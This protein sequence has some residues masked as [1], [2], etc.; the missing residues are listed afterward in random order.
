MKNFN[1]KALFAAVFFAFGF[2]TISS[3]LSA[4][5]RSITVYQFRRVPDEKREEFIKR[6]TTYW[7]KVA[8]KAV[9]NKTMTF[10]AL[11]EKVSG[12]D[13]PNSSNFLFVNTFPNIDKIEE[14]FSNVE[15]VAGV[16]IQEMETNSMSVTTSQIFLHSINWVQ[17]K[18]ANPEKDFNYVV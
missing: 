4:Q 12:Y 16:K 15:T 13:M 7:S 10:W 1:R 6:E 2:T 9:K 14:V 3:N 17:Q 11:F 5:D 18:T 8:E